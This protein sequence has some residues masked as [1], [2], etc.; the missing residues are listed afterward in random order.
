MSS[1]DSHIA[2]K[3]SNRE[4]TEGNGEAY[5]IRITDLLLFS[6]R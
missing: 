4:H 3:Q 6:A 1:F 5:V 2:D